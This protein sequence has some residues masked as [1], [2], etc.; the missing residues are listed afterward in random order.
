[1]SRLPHI[2]DALQVLLL[3]A[4]QELKSGEAA[5]HVFRPLCGTGGD[6]RQK[7]VLRTYMQ[8]WCEQC[9]FCLS[10]RNATPKHKLKL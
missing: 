1:M 8:R 9:A 6:Y 4:A 10:S 2:A 5:V 3:V 7:E